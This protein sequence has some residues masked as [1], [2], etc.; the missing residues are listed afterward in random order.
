MNENYDIFNKF[1]MKFVPD[2]TVDVKSA[3]SQVGHKSV[4]ISQWAIS[5]L[6]LYL[7]S[8]LFIPFVTLESFDSK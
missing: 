1:L 8:C 6:G 2:G 4:E 7:N 3:L 5:I